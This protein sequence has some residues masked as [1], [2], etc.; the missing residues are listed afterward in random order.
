MTHDT[1]RL[2]GGPGSPYSLKMRAILRYRRLPH[3]W[4]VP[5]GYIGTGG[6]LA[7]A[8][9]G[10]IPVVQYPDGGYRADS[11]PIAYDLERRHPGVR[12]IVPDDPAQAFVS[13]L[14][15]DMADEML[16]TAMFEMRWASAEDQAFCATR[17]LSG[18]L[19]PIPRAELDEIV[20]RFTGRQT[21]LRAKL[22]QDEGVAPLRRLYADVLSVVERMLDASPYLLGTRPSLGDFGLYAQLH[23]CS[24]DPT[25][26]AIMRRDAPRTF[27]WTHA[28]DDASGVDGEWGA[29][30]VWSDAVHGML[31]IAG[32]WYLPAMLANAQA[33]AA[34]ERRYA[35]RLDGL[36]WAARTDPYKV[37]CLGWLRRDLAA[38]PADALGALR[39]LLERHGC[40][41]A[42]CPGA[43]PAL[44]V[45]PMAPM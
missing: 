15:E 8:G 35:T 17:Q 10:I 3:V 38:L 45:P 42:L 12:S 31:S 13:H 7:Q 4:I 18:W 34:G 1:Y 20:L 9:K 25:A 23:Q 30:G 14:I 24:I 5:R 40:W 44:D 22:V 32:R 16:V 43:S 2:L 11:T 28:L 41:A 6:E 33:A 37:K 21:T 39:P 19:S 29:P 36:A 26:S 27:Q